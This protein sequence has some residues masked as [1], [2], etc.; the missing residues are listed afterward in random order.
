MGVSE[1]DW[2]EDEDSGMDQEASMPSGRIVVE[3]EVIRESCMLL[4]P[5]S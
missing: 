2:G 5:N 3:E 1:G 4:V